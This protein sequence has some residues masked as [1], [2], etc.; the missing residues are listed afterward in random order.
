MIWRPLK[1]RAGG[2]LLLALALELA[3]PAGH[4]AVGALLDHGG[5]APH[6]AGFAHAEAAHGLLVRRELVGVEDALGADE[7]RVAVLGQVLAAGT[8]GVLGGLGGRLQLHLLPGLVVRGGG[9]AE[10]LPDG[11]HGGGPEDAEALPGL[12][13]LRGF[14]RGAVHLKPE[15]LLV[16]LLLQNGLRNHGVARPEVI[17][18]DAGALKEAKVLHDERRLGGLLEG[19]AAGKG[20]ARAHEGAAEG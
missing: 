9:E 3:A 6:H 5:H 20:S 7:A 1:A 15:A 12:D 19:A 4:A 10:A 14:L 13:E 16:E 17:E 8:R 11:R 18:T 2:C